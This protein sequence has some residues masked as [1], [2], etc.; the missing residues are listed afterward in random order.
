MKRLKLNSTIP[1]LVLITCFIVS[2]P[3]K[4]ETISVEGIYSGTAIWAVDTVKVTG[5]VTITGALIIG[6]GAY[7]EFQG[8]FEIAAESIYALGGNCDQITITINDTTGFS[9]IDLPGGGWKRLRAVN[10]MVINYCNIMFG[11][12]YC[13]DGSEEGI[14]KIENES[15]NALQINNSVIANI[16]CKEDLTADS[17]L[18]NSEAGPAVEV[19]ITNSSFTNCEFG[20]LSNARSKVNNCR[21]SGSSCGIVGTHVQNSFFEDNEVIYLNGCDGWSLSIENCVFSNNDALDISSALAPLQIIGSLFINNTLKQG[22]PNAYSSSP[23]IVNNTFA[24]NKIT[25]TYNTILT[26]WKSRLFSGL[27][28]WNNIFY[29]NITNHPEGK[30]ISFMNS[31]GVGPL[32]GSFKNNLVEG[33]QGAIEYSSIEGEYVNNIDADPLFI[34]VANQNF[35]LRRCSPCI[36]TGT[37][38]SPGIELP[39]TDLDGNPRILDGK[40][41]IGVYEHSPV[42][43]C[44][45]WLRHFLMNLRQHLRQGLFSRSVKS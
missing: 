42:H 22:F 9:D 17:W 15:L 6:P 41:D 36:N 26:F 32:F 40:K 44:F 43:R 1:L 27:Y 7:V 30:Q 21:F 25:G 11:K 39:A 33:G 14:L 18:T 38:D 10:N 29:G 8:H 4:A 23:V 37:N 16:Y 19:K 34:S 13:T 3:L 31:E 45:C 2:L 20:Y 24:N 12:Y 5:D 35:H 28:F